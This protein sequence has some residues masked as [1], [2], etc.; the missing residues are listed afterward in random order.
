[1]N[2]GRE[3]PVGKP[4]PLWNAVFE[5]LQR[6]IRQGRYEKTFPSEA[7]LVRRFG[8]G[9]QT[10][11]RVMNELVEAGL[12]ERRQGSGTVVSRRVR[13]KLGDV[14]LIMPNLTSTPF[15]NAMAAACKEAGYA[16]RFH[17]LG[18][19]RFVLKGNVPV[20][21]RMKDA[22]RFV[23]ELADENVMGVVMQ[24]LELIDDVERINGLILSA[25]QKRRIPVVLVDFDV[26]KP[27]ARS[28]C[29]IVCMDNFHAGYAI[30]RHLIERGARKI[31]VHLMEKYAPSIIERM[32]GAAM[33][34]SE[35]GLEWDRSRNVF[36]CR[37]D[38][39][40]GIA[41][42]LRRFRAD[43]VVC[44]ND[45]IAARML[46]TLKQLGFSVP[47]DIRVTGIDDG[48]LAQL[49]SPALTTIRQDFEE[50]ARIAAERLIWR[51]RNPAAPPVTIQV[52]GELI[53]R[54][55]T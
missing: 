17:E 20:R 42:A 5:T 4:R 47:G 26:C 29:D 28:A 24:P 30:A 16:L 33:A 52:P 35:A 39:K 36:G 1:M 2:V 13:Q 27:P 14:G 31:A 44:G 6:E 8:V 49:V 23:K 12:V 7:Q 3:I 11:V 18:N 48:E 34:V 50:I 43:A 55:S 41:D 25:F 45:L 9:R 46:K 37:A 53:V 21:K 38:D 51:I 22:I 32:H 15:T 40:E 10:I 19:G 54:E